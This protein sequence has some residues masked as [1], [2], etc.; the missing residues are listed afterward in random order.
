GQNPIGHQLKPAGKGP[1][2]TVVGVV[3]DVRQAGIQSPV[4]TEIY[5]P[6][7]QARLLLSG[8]VPRSMNLVLRV[9]GDA[10]SPASALSLE[11]RQMDPGAVVSA[12]APLQAAIDRTI[13]QPRLLA[14]MF[15]TFAVLA[16]A[17]AGIGVYAVTSFAVNSRTSEFG[18]RMALGAEPFDALRLLMSSGSAAIG[19]GLA[20]GLAATAGVAGILR[21]LLFGVGALD[22][23]SLVLGALLIALI[24]TIATLVPAI[25][26]T[27]I[28]PVSALREW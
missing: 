24:A 10:M 21:N 1:W 18:L 7:R 6:H 20:A 2:F 4:G 26:A 5:V 19:V 17:V 28:D 27:R 12:I 23:R 8:F 9:D 22:T 13:A 11:I 25:R 15:A 3:A 14:W 16:L